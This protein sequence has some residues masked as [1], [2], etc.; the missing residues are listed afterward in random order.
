MKTPGSWH[1]ASTQWD[2]WGLTWGQEV[3]W[4]QVVRWAQVAQWVPDT[5]QTALEWVLVRGGWVLWVLKE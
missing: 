4:G 5:G 3:P 1:L 2:L